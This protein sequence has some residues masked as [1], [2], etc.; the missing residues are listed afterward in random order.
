MRYLDPKADWP[1]IETFGKHPDL[2]ICFLNALLP[3]AE[4]EYITEIEYLPVHLM[5]QTPLRDYSIVDVRCRDERGRIF[6]VEMQML[7]SPAFMHRV[8]FNASKACLL[9]TSPSPRD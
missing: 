1:F 2:T 5:P 6:I 3:L 8:L 7:W 4:N 9:Y